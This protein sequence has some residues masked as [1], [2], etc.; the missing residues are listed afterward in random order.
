MSGANTSTSESNMDSL[1]WLIDPVTRQEFERNFY[2]RQLCLVTRSNPSYYADLLSV[3]DL[4]TILGTHDVTQTEV[5]LVRGEQDVPRRS[6]ASASGRIDPLELASRFDEGSTIVFDQLHRRVPALARLCVSIG[7]IFGS[8]VQTNIYYTPPHAQ[9]FKPHWD[10]HDVFVLQVAGKKDWSIYDTKVTLPLTGQSFDPDQHEPGP[11]SKVFQLGPGDVAYLPRGLMHAATSSDHASLHITLGLTAFTWTDFFLE[12]VAAAALEEES[13]RQTLPLGFADGSCSQ[14]DRDRLYREKLEL[15][16]S[17]FD[18][19]PVWRHF[20][21]ELLA[22]NTPLLT[23]LLGS[24]LRTDPLTLD[25]RLG[26]RPDLAV[27]LKNDG[28]HCVLRFSRRELT[29]PTRVFA[30][31]EFVTTRDV[32]AVQDL[33]D[34]LDAEGKVTLVRRLLKEGLLQF[35]ASC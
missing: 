14:E 11:L 2:E 9:G 34:C 33:P 13:L 21:D 19:M 24:R 16:H 26:R 1:V 7:K 8:R 28:D 6:Y 22:A 32:F 17:K 4:D 35:Q 3:A 30:A 18:P 29:L 10:T 31:V 27:E 20:Q 25:S 15:L 23:D 12:S 5:K